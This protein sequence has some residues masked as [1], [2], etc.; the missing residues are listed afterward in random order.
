MK[1]VQACFCRLCEEINTFITK[2]I[3]IVNKKIPISA[4][5]CYFTDFGRFSL[6][7]IMTSQERF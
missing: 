6:A 2:D 3:V 1:E 5:K 4:L 7:Q